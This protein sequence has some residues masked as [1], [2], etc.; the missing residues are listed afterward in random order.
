[1]RLDDS[2][3]ALWNGSISHFYLLVECDYPCI[4]SPNTLACKSLFFDLVVDTYCVSME[5]TLPVRDIQ[6][7]QN[8]DDIIGTCKAGMIT[9]K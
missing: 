4:V 1:M 3:G 9:I 8:L 7:V 2:F 6:V 5:V